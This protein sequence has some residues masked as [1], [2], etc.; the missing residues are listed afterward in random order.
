M[1]SA[2]AATS[3]AATAN[4]PPDVV[5]AAH[6]HVAGLA[7]I[8][9]AQASVDTFRASDP[10]ALTTRR[11]L[12]HSPRLLK[13]HSQSRRV[14]LYVYAPPRTARWSDGNLSTRFP[15]CTTFQW[16]GDYE[17]IQ[18]MRASTQATKSGDDADFYIVPFLTKCYFNNVARYRLKP[19]DT[20]LQHVLAY[21]R[22]AGP[23][24]DRRPEKHLFFFMSGIGAGSVPSW[25]RYLESAIFVVAEGD[26]QAGYFR[27]GHDVIVP[28]KIST[29][30]QAQQK[31]PQRRK[32]LGVF[33]GSLDAALRDAD[34][35]RVRQRNKLRRRLFDAL[36]SQG[37]QFIFSGHK[38]KKYVQEMDESRFCIIP[39]GNTPWTRRFFDAVVRGCIPAVLSDPVAFPF[40]RLLD[41]RRMTIKL[42][43]Q[44][45]DRLADELRNVNASALTSL[46]ANL[47]RFWPAFV[48]ARGVA[49]DMLLLELAARKHRFYDTWQAATP[50]SVHHFWSPQHGTFVLPDSKK[51]GPS[52]GAGAT[53]HR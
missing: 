20:A 21:L 4:A 23:W 28:G 45:L 13:L 38:S 27:E 52:W 8:A 12:Q 16:S 44:W 10:D 31:R 42:P 29:K 15:R 53:A 6:A 22:G 39:R 35:G 43:E 50:N 5:D 7:A 41:F 32:L 30:H 47:E 1:H 46:H 36:G 49:F 9:T 19:M 17:L 25:Q 37:K 3:P 33:R 18:R 2:A 26:R 11:M 48:Y 14:R 51:V 34:G 24:W 40:E